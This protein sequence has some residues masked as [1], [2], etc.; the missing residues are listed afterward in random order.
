[1]TPAT[2]TQIIAA[3]KRRISVLLPDRNTKDRLKA[4]LVKEAKTA[5]VPA[6]VGDK[7]PCDARA[8]AAATAL[9]LDIKPPITLTK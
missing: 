7:L 8:A 4:M 9:A 1:M 6:T 5:P 3:A 2:A